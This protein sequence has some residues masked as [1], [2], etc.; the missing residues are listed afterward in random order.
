LQPLRS[1]KL[2]QEAGKER[3]YNVDYK[4]SE[5]A[6]H[7]EQIRDKKPRSYITP[8]PDSI[9]DAFTWFLHL[10]R[11]DDLAIG[12]K[13]DYFIYDGWKLSRV[14]LHV[15]AEESVL[16]PL[17]WVKSWKLDLEREILRSAFD[18]TDAKSKGRAARPPILKVITPAK[19]TGALWISQDARR[20]PVKIKMESTI[21][22]G[23]VELARHIPA[24]PAA[25]E[26]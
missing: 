13:L 20:L 26:L 18:M 6:A 5:Y 10:R 25:R 24:A 17:G 16:T 9:H 2:I 22:T 3:V 4:V 19:P 12:L 21:G 8:V 23:V 11:R 7:V 14:A 15:V 1:E